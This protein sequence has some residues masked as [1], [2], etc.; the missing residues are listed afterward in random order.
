LRV[1]PDLDILLEPGDRLFIP[2]RSSTVT[3]SGEVLNSGSFQYEPGLTL[4]EYIDGA[5]GTT[6]GA[7]RDRIFVVLPNGTARP[8]AENWLSFNT[9]NLIPPGSTVVVPRDLRPFNLSQFLKDATAITSQ[10]AITVASF[11]VLNRR[12]P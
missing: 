4:D 8:V 1:R 9:T 6:S 11:A 5:G 3:V 10:I 12:Y 7:D 2:K